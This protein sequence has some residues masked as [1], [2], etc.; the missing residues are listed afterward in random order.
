MHLHGHQFAVEKADGYP[1]EC[2]DRMLKNTILVA[3]GETWD[4]VFKANN[5]GIWP[6]H[7][8]IAHHVS[9]NFTDGTGGMFTTLVYQK[10]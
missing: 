1:I 8:H 4:V 7:C 5:P 6:I 2:Y 3:S 10:R 9:N